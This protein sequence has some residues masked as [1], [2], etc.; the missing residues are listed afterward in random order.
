MHVKKI[1]HAANA[2]DGSLQITSKSDSE[3]NLGHFALK[4]N[5]LPLGY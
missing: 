1:I 3:F 5:T 2:G 4:A